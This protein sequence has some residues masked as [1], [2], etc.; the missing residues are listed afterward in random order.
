MQAF[1]I[2]ARPALDSFPAALDRVKMAIYVQC[3]RWGMPCPVTGGQGHIVQ[4][5]DPSSEGRAIG[6]S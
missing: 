6:V 5:N 2:N 1:E 3:A 4:D